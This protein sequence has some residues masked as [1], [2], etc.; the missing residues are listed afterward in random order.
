MKYT[1]TQIDEALS[2]WKRQEKKFML[3][4]AIEAADLDKEVEKTEKEAQIAMN[5]LA[6]AQ[7]V[8]D[9]ASL[10]EPAVDAPVQTT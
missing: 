4:E 9:M 1:K 3:Q 8:H 5:K 6:V 2:Y 7:A 10:A